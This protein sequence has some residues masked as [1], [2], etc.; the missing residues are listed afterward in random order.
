TIIN[1]AKWAFRDMAALL[2]TAIDASDKTRRDTGHAVPPPK[3]AEQQQPETAETEA[4]R[5]C[6]PM[7][8]P[9]ES[10]ARGPARAR[11]P[12]RVERDRRDE[13]RLPK[14]IKRRGSCPVGERRSGRA[15]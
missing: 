2:K 13:T 12:D 3:P 9:R 4:N 1:P 11:V 8:A 5:R 14:S 10:P 6:A 7:D 15:A